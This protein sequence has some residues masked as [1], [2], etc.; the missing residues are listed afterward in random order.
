MQRVIEYINFDPQT[1]LK[2]MRQQL[3]EALSI[4]E[5]ASYEATQSAINKWKE[6]KKSFS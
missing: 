1:V 6:K 2:T 4:G 5:M 3:D